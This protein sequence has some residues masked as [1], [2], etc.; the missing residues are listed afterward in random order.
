MRGCQNVDIFNDFKRRVIAEM[1]I[2]SCAKL[3]GGA[4]TP[5]KRL[6]MSGKKILTTK[7]REDFGQLVDR[8]GGERW[9]TKISSLTEKIET[10]KRKAR[11]VPS[12]VL[13]V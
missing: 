4:L 8:S 7:K 9:D 2:A 1:Q 10:E 11:V 3:L 5:R 13:V 6:V 12:F